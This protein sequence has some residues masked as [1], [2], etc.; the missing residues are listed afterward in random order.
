MHCKVKHAGVQHTFN[1]CNF[2]AMQKFLKNQ[3]A[4][5]RKII[6]STG[7]STLCNN[8]TC[9]VAVFPLK[10]WANNFIK[11]NVI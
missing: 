8:I 9:T 7:I 4:L 11:T 10:N 3:N 6:F 1:L 5:L 2:K